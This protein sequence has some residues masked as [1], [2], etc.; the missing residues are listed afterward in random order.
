MSREKMQ[1]GG[2][3]PCGSTSFLMLWLD[4]AQQKHL[5][6]SWP[7]HLPQGFGDTRTGRSRTALVWDRVFL[8]MVVLMGLWCR[9]ANVGAWAKRLGATDLTSRKRGPL[10]WPVISPMS[11]YFRDANCL[12]GDSWLGLLQQ[13]KARLSSV[14]RRPLLSCSTTGWDGRRPSPHG[15]PLT[16]GFPGSRTMSQCISIYYELLSLWCSNTTTQSKQITQKDPRSLSQQLWI[17]YLV[18]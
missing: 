10:L 3:Q 1:P 6:H 11:F 5:A 2:N 7:C 9:N 4:R 16:V 14:T 12:A 17:L 18:S 8:G 13:L 15:G